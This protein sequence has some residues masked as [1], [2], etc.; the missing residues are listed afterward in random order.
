MSVT[1]LRPLGVGEILDVAI[2]IYR[3]NFRALLTLVFVVVAPFEI[4]SALIQ[5][6]A[7]PDSSFLTD[8]TPA[9]AIDIDRDFWLA[10][11]GFAAAGLLS[12][13]AGIVATGA[14]FKAIADG[15][16]GERADWRPALAYAARRLHSILWVTVFGTFIAVLGFVFFVVPGVYL[17]VCFA[18]AVPVLLT[19]GLKGR[20]ALGR[21]RRLVKGRWWGTF[22][23]VVLGAILVSIVEG[24][25]VGLTAVVTTLD[26]ADPTLASFLFTTTAT[27]LASVISTPLSAAF[28]TVLYFDLRVRKEA[29]DLQLLAEQIGVEPGEGASPAARFQDQ[30]PLRESLDPD[31]QP[32]Y[33]P[34]PPGWKPR[35][36]R[37]AE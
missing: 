13:I 16:L 7:L 11:A 31:D 9:E 36:Q 5:A 8:S 27:V 19:E 34:P 33:W 24:A 12:F 21:S 3:R 6:S 17:Y 35:S 29:F 25:L 10:V 26:T 2:T 28:I 22:G 4:V 15:Y 32:P 23:V 20:K 30:V 37:D 1:Q 18:V 14:C